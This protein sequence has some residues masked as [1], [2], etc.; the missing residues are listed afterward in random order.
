[1]YAKYE[2]NRPNSFG[3][4][5]QKPRKCTNARTEGRT[6]KGDLGENSVPLWCLTGWGTKM[7]LDYVQY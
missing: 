7:G 6:L 4:N 1:M 3:E 2:V 5:F